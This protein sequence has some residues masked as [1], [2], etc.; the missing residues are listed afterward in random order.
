MMGLGGVGL[1]SGVGRRTL[2]DSR[3]VVGLESE[4]FLQFPSLQVG[5]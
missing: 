1:G 3:S 2:G 5:H 4:G